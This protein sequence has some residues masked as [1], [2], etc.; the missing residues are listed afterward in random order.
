MLAS[1]GLS[2]IVGDQWLVGSI[3]SHVSSSVYLALGRVSRTKNNQSSDITFEMLC[4]TLPS[5]DSF[6]PC[7]QDPS[8]KADDFQRPL[9]S[10]ASS[11]HGEN[12]IVQS[13]L[14]EH[15]MSDG[16]VTAW[17]HRGKLLF[18]TQ[19][20]ALEQLKRSWTQEENDHTGKRL[21][22]FLNWFQ[23]SH[24]SSCCLWD[25]DSILSLQKIRAVK[26]G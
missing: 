12:D 5:G 24:K 10:E 9:T 17:Q 11:I 1:C 26:I 6:F 7:C 19:D 16:W 18:Q 22:E 20:R 4:P 21:E 8:M 13:V 23:S 2:G 25:V 3:A 14:T 15:T